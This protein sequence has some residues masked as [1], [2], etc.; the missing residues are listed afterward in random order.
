[1]NIGVVVYSWSGNTR[2]VAD[3]LK[4]ALEAAG[5]AVHVVSVPLAAERERGSRE[6]TLAELPDLEPFDGII[7]VA[8]V[9]AFSLS[10]VLAEYL[11]HVEPLRGK[12]V[13]CLVTQQLPYR[14]LGGN[15]AIR[16]MKRLCTAKGATVAGSAIVSWASSRREPSTV[17]AIEE[18][19]G[20][21]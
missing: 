14:W 18:L 17:Q 19:R 11:K 15:R 20:A 10:P 12:R 7:F 16:Q 9:E 5:H 8:A 13:G 3:R 1:M 2:A 6:F 21:F 4:P